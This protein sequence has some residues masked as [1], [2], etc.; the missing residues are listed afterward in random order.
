MAARLLRWCLVLYIAA[1]G[2]HA[3][4]L[5]AV[6]TR[7]AIVARGVEFRPRHDQVNFHYVDG[8][9][10]ITW[11]SSVHWTN[12]IRGHHG[13]PNLICCTRCHYAETT[14]LALKDLDQHL[15]A[16]KCTEKTIEVHLRSSEALE[17]AKQL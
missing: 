9:Q 12:S 10:V 16:L 15:I 2:T 7:S 14:C 17:T 13:R 1:L 6:A 8:I 3:R 5:T 11:K 4:R